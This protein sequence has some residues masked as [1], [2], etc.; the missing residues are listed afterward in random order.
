VRKGRC[1]E[2]KTIDINPT[3][4]TILESIYTYCI[5]NKKNV[6]QLVK[7][8]KAQV[9]EIALSGDPEMLVKILGVL[10]NKINFFLKV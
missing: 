6:F 4:H 1:P 5:T 9:V 3:L 10:T 7:E 8:F 2:G